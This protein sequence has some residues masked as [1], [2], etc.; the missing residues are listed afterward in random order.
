VSVGTTLLVPWP[1]RLLPATGGVGPG[2]C[3][4][5]W[6]SVPARLLPAT[7]DIGPGCGRPWPMDLGLPS[8]ST[9]MAW[10]VADRHRR[11][12]ALDC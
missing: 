11:R 8:A 1:G 10:S 5:V 12:L 2:H 6:S 4:A 9:V 3:G 7:N